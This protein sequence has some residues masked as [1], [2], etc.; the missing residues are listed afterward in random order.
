[1]KKINIST[2]AM[3]MVSFWITSCATTSGTGAGQSGSPKWGV[4]FTTPQVNNSVMQVVRSTAQTGEQSIELYSGFLFMGPA[5]WLK[6]KDID[7]SIQNIGTPSSVID[8][9]SGQQME[10]RVFQKD[11]VRDLLENQAY[12]DLCKR[13]SL[14]APRA[15]TTSEREMFYYTIPFEINSEPISVVQ[16]E[17]EVLLV[18]VSNESGAGWLDLISDYRMK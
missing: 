12:I 16:Y 18:M 8:P 15:A 2:S 9:N 10:I 7:S 17:K 5:L 14:G 11:Q 13:I 1:M 3:I 6:L 4:E